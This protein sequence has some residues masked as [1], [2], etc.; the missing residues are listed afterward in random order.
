[1]K[2]T[3]GASQAFAKQA[4]PYSHDLGVALVAGLPGVQHA[5]PKT[6]KLCM[7]VTSARATR[8]VKGG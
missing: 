7:K 3:E 8:V 1:M 2:P 4:P 6:L 5:A